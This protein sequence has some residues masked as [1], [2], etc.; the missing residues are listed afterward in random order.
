MLVEQSIFWTSAVAIVFDGIRS[1][2]SVIFFVIQ[3]VIALWNEI[4]SG[5]VTCSQTSRTTFI[6]LLIT[7]AK[8]VKSTEN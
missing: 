8:K 7:E 5:N 4:K 2:L 1:K 6:Q 3:S